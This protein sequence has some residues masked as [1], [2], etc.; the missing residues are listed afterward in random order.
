MPSGDRDHRGRRDSRDRRGDRDPG[1]GGVGRPGRARRSTTVGSVAGA[2]ADR[3]VRDEPRMGPR[4][5]PSPVQR[6]RR[7]TPPAPTGRSSP[8]PRPA[9]S[10]R[11]PSQLD[12][13]GAETAGDVI[14][15]QL[16]RGVGDRNKGAFV[17]REAPVAVAVGHADVRA[18]LVQPDVAAA[19]R[20][21]HPVVQLVDDR[22]RQVLERDEVDDVVVL[23]EVALDLDGRPIVMAVD[24]LA[25]IALIGDEV[26][27]AEDEVVLGDPDLEAGDGMTVEPSVRIPIAVPILVCRVCSVASTPAAS[28]NGPWT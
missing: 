9:A 3:R 1:A 4:I 14:G 7:A 6:R 25:L 8:R 5:R 21:H 22:L 12:H 11:G 20:Q 16:G 27:R 13:R 23:V 15:Q 17:A 10:R 2:G 24:P 28:T 26:A 18:V 19:G